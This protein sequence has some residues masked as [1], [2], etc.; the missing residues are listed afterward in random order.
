MRTSTSPASPPAPAT[1]ARCRRGCWTTP[2]PSRRTPSCPP[3]RGASPWGSCGAWRRPPSTSG[4]RRGSAPASGRRTSSCG[5]RRA[6]TTTTRCAR[7]HPATPTAA[8]AP[9]ASG[10]TRRAAG[11]AP[12]PPTPWPRMPSAAA[13]WRCT[14]RSR[15]CTFTRATT[16]VVSPRA[17]AVCPSSG[18]RASASRRSTSRTAQTSLV[19]LPSSWS[20]V[21]H[22]RPRQSSGS[23]TRRAPRDRRCFEVF[24][25]PHSCLE[26]QK[27]S[28][29]TK[30][31]AKI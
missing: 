7:P 27:P 10:A 14:P 21:R 19:S 5:S 24:T 11:C 9:W 23:R 3:T 12:G 13:P 4:S 2:S 8:P 6:T 31:W 1:P 18:G 26:S 22:G 29:W 17:R 15:P 30:V 28:H 16:S 25:C 20:Q